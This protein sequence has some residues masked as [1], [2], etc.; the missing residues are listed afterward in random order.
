MMK[1][2]TLGLARFQLYGDRTLA[3]FNRSV[4]LL[5][6]KE[7]NCFLTGNSFGI[8]FEHAPFMPLPFPPSKQRTE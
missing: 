3:H 8:A 7:D 1:Q 6:I 4:Q 5:E 2:I